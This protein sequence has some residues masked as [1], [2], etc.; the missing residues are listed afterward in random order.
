M[1][2]WFAT[3]QCIEADPVSSQVD[4][5]ANQTRT[6]VGADVEGVAQKCGSPFG[7]GPTQEDHRAFPR[8]LPIQSPG[9]GKAATPRGRLHARRRLLV[10]CG[11]KSAR[12]TLHPQEAFEGEAIPTSRLPTAVEVLDVCLKACLAWRREDWS[13]PQRQAQPNHATERIG[14]S[15]RSLEDRV[16][17]ELCVAWPPV[18]SPMFDQRI[19]GD[20]RR[21]PA[22]GPRVA[23]ASMQAHRGEYIHVV[24]TRDHQVLDDVETV[25]VDSL[26]RYVREEPTPRRRWSSHAPLAIQGSATFQNASDRSHGGH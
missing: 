3:T 8:R 23:A 25:E 9:A 17:V 4:F 14:M 19:H 1:L 22:T 6:P 15:M 10:M 26:R 11:D 7:I 12:L 24:A 20:F 21:D 5:G 16:V 18:L 2:F 13:D